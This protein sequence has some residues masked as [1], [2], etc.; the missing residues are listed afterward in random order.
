MTSKKLQKIGNIIFLVDF[1]IFA[2]FIYFNYD[3]WGG[4]YIWLSW[5]YKIFVDNVFIHTNR[6]SI[7]SFW[8][9]IKKK[10]FK[11]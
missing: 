6:D 11:I 7:N 1:N 2:V 4:K 5:I 9:E 10:Q 8:D 3:C